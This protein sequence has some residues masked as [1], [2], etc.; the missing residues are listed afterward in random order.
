MDSGASEMPLVSV[1]LPA[2][3]VTAYIRETLDSIMAQTLQDFE[4]ILVNDGCPDT[5]NLEAALQPYLGRIRYIKQENGGPSAARNTGIAAASGEYVAFLDSDD[6]WLPDYIASQSAFFR[7]HP[8]IDVVYADGE[9][10]GES[11]QAG[12][13]FMDLCP[14]DGEVTVE[15]LLLERCTVLT[16]SVMARRSALERAAGFDRQFRGPE[17]FDLWL[18]VLKTGGKIGYQ[19]R[20]LLRHRKHSSSLSANSQNMRDGLSRVLDKL[21][22]SQNLTIPESKALARM[23]H[24]L[25]ALEQLAAGKR[26]LRAGDAAAA[27]AALAGA[28]TYFR[29]LKLRAVLLLLRI[30]P[31]ATWFWKSRTSQ[32]ADS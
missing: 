4:V 30:A 15:T 29:S 31:A 8:E 32:E 3:R 11:K 22:Q 24:R 1:I 25:R 7:D 23:R 28:S 13:R 26:H 19:R 27:R 21:E 9:L 16:S 2:Y 17:D 5:A 14:S 20:V 12:K 6:V 10:F 18:R